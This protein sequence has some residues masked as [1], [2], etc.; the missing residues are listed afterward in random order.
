MH[1]KQLEY[2]VKTS[3]YQSLNKAADA[4]Y[5]SQPSLNYTLTE[6]EKELDIKLFTRS[7]SGIRLTDSGLK[8]LE[9]AKKI[10]EIASGWD[11][12]A[13]SRRNSLA[14]IGESFIAD[15]L[16]P[17]III[18]CRDDDISLQAYSKP[19]SSIL[20][21]DADNEQRILLDLVALED[22]PSILSR[23]QQ[24]GW[25]YS[26]LKNGNSVI[27][28]SRQSPL[29]AREFVTLADLK[30]NY[31]LVTRSP[32]K[33]HSTHWDFINSFDAQHVLFVP[34]QNAE[35]KLIA[36]EKYAFTTRS[37]LSR[38]YS[39][40]EESSLFSAI[41][42]R[43]TALSDALIAFYPATGDKNLIEKI[44]SIIKALL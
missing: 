35:L 17:D 39:G 22:F 33:I 24:N 30:E 3:Q 43:E 19:V 11:M 41:D 28:T 14:L 10:L 9:D 6:L 36:S 16:I 20:A 25:G 34:S 12:L 1:L 42:L 8:V 37:F 18:A 38:R 26:V 23:A 29:A 13:E 32:E 31:T 21:S 27:L 44:L 4:L 40:Q 5:M 15:E 7:K 2:F